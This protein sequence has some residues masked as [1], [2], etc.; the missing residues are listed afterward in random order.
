MIVQAYNIHHA[1][2]STHLIDHCTGTDGFDDVI[3]TSQCPATYH[4]SGG[5]TN[6]DE[7]PTTHFCQDGAMAI[8]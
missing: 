5:A 8:Y 4:Y 1:T 7:D 6:I 2:T 3:G